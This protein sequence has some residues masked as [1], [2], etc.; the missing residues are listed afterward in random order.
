[1]SRLAMFFYTVLFFY[2]FRFSHLQEIQLE[3]EASRRAEDR[4]KG[5]ENRDN[6]SHNH[7]HQAH[8]TAHQHSLQS[9][10]IQH[11]GSASNN[12]NTNHNN[13]NH[14]SRSGSM[15]DYD[16]LNTQQHLHYLNQLAR[17][18][19]SIH[20]TKKNAILH[21]THATNGDTHYTYTHL[22]PH[23]NVSQHAAPLHTTSHSTAQHSTSQLHS[24]SRSYDESIRSFIEHDEQLLDRDV[25][26]QTH[27]ALQQEPKHD[28]KHGTLNDHEHSRPPPWRPASAPS[29]GNANGS[30]SNNN[31][32]N[33]NSQASASTRSSIVNTALRNSFSDF[34]P[35]SAVEA[36]HATAN[37]TNSNHSQRIPISTTQAS[38]SDSELEPST[39]RA[40]SSSAVSFIR[41][42]VINSGF[43]PVTIHSRAGSAEKTRIANITNSY[44]AGKVG[45][46]ELRQSDTSHSRVVSD[47]YGSVVSS[48]YSSSVASPDA[49]SR[50]DS[51][52]SLQSGASSKGQFNRLQALY[53]KVTNKTV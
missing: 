12:S 40:S 7:S 50:A 47:T 30:A 27:L 46:A 1:M 17:E 5:L 45:V 26:M 4:L 34:S 31:I 15:E 14:R 2:F 52:L 23:A 36:Y 9:S 41:Q 28:A 3:R 24:T 43:S 37:P 20:P 35:P 29:H 18:G 25:V 51:N 11:R 53:E 8:N 42:K 38:M 16:A 19:M 48:H 22:P 39:R 44:S 49:R 33:V 6:H 10:H 21:P 32:A 13:V